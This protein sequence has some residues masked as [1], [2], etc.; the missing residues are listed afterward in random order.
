MP[1][2]KFNVTMLAGNAALTTGNGA[3]VAELVSPRLRTKVDLSRVTECRLV[4]ACSEVGASGFKLR[5]QFSTDESTWQF[6]G[7]DAAGIA[8]FVTLDTLN[9]RVSP[10]TNINYAA[11]HG[12]ADGVFLR[13]AT[14]DGDGANT[15]DLGA[16]SVEFR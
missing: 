3:G 6:L 12:V 4:A 1:S 7:S 8:P 10:W 15:A 13:L 11:N 14:Q 5:V 16:V 9:T 2:I